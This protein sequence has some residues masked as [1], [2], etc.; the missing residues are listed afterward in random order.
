TSHVSE[1]RN[2]GQTRIVLGYGISQ[3]ANQGRPR[4]NIGN[5]PAWKSAK[6]VIASANRLM[7]ER[8]FCSRSSKNAE[9]NVPAWPI[10][11]H[12]TKFVM[13][14]AHATGMSFPKVPMPVRKT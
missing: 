13:G 5:K 3:Y 7:L 2:C 6:R 9:M 12:Q 14:K 4:C 8:H 1:L 11:I 10:P